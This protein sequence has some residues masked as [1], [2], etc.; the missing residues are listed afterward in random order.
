MCVTGVC[1]CHSRSSPHDGMQYL[2]LC[3]QPEQVFEALLRY[4]EEH[5]RK[6]VVHEQQVDCVRDSP[7][8][9]DST[10]STADED[11]EDAL[12]T[13]SE[14]IVCCSTAWD[15]R[16]A[17]VA[18]SGIPW[19][20]GT[21]GSAADGLTA[22]NTEYSL[23]LST[24]AVPPSALSLI[25]CEPA[26]CPSPTHLAV[27]AITATSSATSVLSEMS[28]E[29]F[30]LDTEQPPAPSSLNLALFRPPRSITPSPPE[31][32]EGDMFAPYKIG[33]GWSGPLPSLLYGLTGVPEE[34]EGSADLSPQTPDS[35]E[36][37]WEVQEA[38]IAFN[39]DLPLQVVAPQCTLRV[40]VVVTSQGEA[41]AMTSSPPPG[42][43][44]Y[45]TGRPTP[46]CPAGEEEY[47][48]HFCDAVM[49][50]SRPCVTQ[51]WS[52]DCD[53]SIGVEL[54][55]GLVSNTSPQPDEVPRGP[56][57]TVP[58]SVAQQEC[59]SADV[60]A[61]LELVKRVRQDHLPYM[62][63]VLWVW[64]GEQQPLT[65]QEEEEEEPCFH[66]RWQDVPCV[67]VVVTCQAQIVVA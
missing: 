13:D 64:F 37:P 25:G 5:K 26:I 19:S 8:L 24:S 47:W 20:V 55:S 41:A 6:G 54:Q 34:Q 52:V 57:S 17:S 35:Y 15:G 66:L 42:L 53:S 36:W 56:A 48:L 67:E 22:Q 30:Y 31:S 51:T 50:C 28:D 33:D 65:K 4:A 49:D 10:E 23:T 59:A 11:E 29:V 61:P 18:V 46:T 38:R 60:K 21:S 9:E 16:T 3:Q 62:S 58:H 39:E 7:M 1:V 63:E 27:P 44:S 45:H 14:T 40:C 2:L 32:V 43:G 12:Q